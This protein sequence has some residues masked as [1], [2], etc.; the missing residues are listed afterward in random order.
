MFYR[1][2]VLKKGN[3]VCSR[4]NAQDFLKFIVH[5]DG[6]F[7]HRVSYATVLQTN[8]VAVAH[9]VL[10]FLAMTFAVFNGYGFYLNAQPVIDGVQHFT[11]HAEKGRCIGWPAN[12]GIWNWDDEILV[13]YDHGEFKDKPIGSHDIN[14]DKPIVID[15]SSSLDGGLSWAH[16]TTNIYDTKLGESLDN[17]VS[18]EL[19]QKS[20]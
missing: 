18:N 3:V 6:D 19:L 16:E 9:F 12:G 2:V 10:L 7:A 14:D 15:Q 8:I 17:I 11:V 4:F 5:F 1:A 20:N 13:M